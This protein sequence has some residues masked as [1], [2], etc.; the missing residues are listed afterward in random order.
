M[1]AL[2]LRYNAPLYD[3]RSKIVH[4]TLLSPQLDTAIFCILSIIMMICLMF[5][6][7]P[8]SSH[9]RLSVSVL[10]LLALIPL[11]F[12][13]GAS[14]LITPLLFV[15]ASISM[16]LTLMEIKGS[17]AFWVSLKKIFLYVIVI[18]T[19]IELEAVALW[20]SAPLSPTKIFLPDVE[21]IKLETELFYI[22]QGFVLP[23]LVL[24]FFF[25]AFF[26]IKALFQVKGLKFKTITLNFNF[27]LKLSGQSSW[28]FNACFLKV[29]LLSIS[30]CSILLVLFLTY[31]PYSPILNP[32]GAYK[33]VDIPQYVEWL[34]KAA[35][36]PMMDVFPQNRLLSLMFLYL[37][38]KATGLSALMAVQSF[39]II[40]GIL[41]VISVSYFLYSLRVDYTTKVFSVLFTVLSFHVTTAIF[42]GFLSNLT[43]LVGVYIFSAFFVKA[44]ERRSWRWIGLATATMGLLLF[45][46]SY[47]W[48]MLMGVL[49]V[50]AV[51]HVVK[52]LRVRGSM[53]EFR[54]VGAILIV[55]ILL[56]FARNTIINRMGV[57]VEATRVAGSNLSLRNIS[58]FW[59]TLGKSVSQ[60]M[61]G[62][63]MNPLMYVL[64][65]F[66]AFV[67]FT[68]WDKPFY[69]YLGCWLVASSVPLLFA[70]GKIQIRIL[71]N[72]PFQIL[73]AI[74]L[75]VI[76]KSLNGDSKVDKVLRWVL[77]LWVILV[78]LNYA[79]RCMYVISQFS[80]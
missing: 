64:A 6:K 10:A 15:V 72:I 62:T 76:L 34:S 23:I 13:I 70:S 51:F 52:W 71:Y 58:F 36:S 41:L 24:T 2:A 49:V 4:I 16:I 40:L 14:S 8:W 11:L 28:R 69:R 31:Y 29:S 63:L 3:F 5:A 35:I 18:L 9:T 65:M 53:E 42:G 55:N 33:G 32:L 22:S 67:V 78:N 39:M 57:A 38:W 45:I 12:L 21:I 44:M 61:E 56:D 50:Y 17:Y 25:W 68:C 30:I 74:G 1:N 46:H 20:L 80:F 43:C 59:D 37:F 75:S 60:G 54:L 73:A 79:F 77:V 27:K 19:I 66:G 26:V 47:T 48:A 7:R